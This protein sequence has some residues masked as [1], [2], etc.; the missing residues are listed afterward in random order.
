[1]IRVGH[2]HDLV[3]GRVLAVYRDPRCF[4][5]GEPD[6]EQ[7]RPVSRLHDEYFGTLGE[8]IYLPRQAAAQAAPEAR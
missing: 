4:P 5:N 8:V 1:V 6:F 7:F 2:G 3:V